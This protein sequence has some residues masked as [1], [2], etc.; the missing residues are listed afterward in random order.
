MNTSLYTLINNQLGV[1]RNLN[2]NMLLIEDLGFNSLQLME[3]I[4][5]I[6][7]TYDISFDE[8]DLLFESFDKIGDLRAI[9]E[10][11]E[12]EQH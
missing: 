5:D 2:D 12:E 3:L 10:Q 11:L 4:I 6:E 9:I 7:D 1:T 8:A